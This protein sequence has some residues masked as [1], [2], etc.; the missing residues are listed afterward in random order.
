MAG[1]HCCPRGNDFFQS[2]ATTDNVKAAIPMRPPIITDGPMA[3]TA[4]FMNRKDDPQIAPSA[5]SQAN[6]AGRKELYRNYMIL[7]D[8]FYRPKITS[9]TNLLPI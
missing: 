8:N 7:N 9:S 1:V 4:I 2:H 6:C 5:I 3:G